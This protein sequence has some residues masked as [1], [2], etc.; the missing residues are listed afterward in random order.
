[1]SNAGTLYMETF[2]ENAIDLRKAI[3]DQFRNITISAFDPFFLLQKIILF[4]GRWLLSLRITLTPG[5][6]LCTKIKDFSEINFLKNFFKIFFAQVNL[7]HRLVAR[8][9][10]FS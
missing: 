4:G 9:G 6:W 3:A 1:M 5:C 10:Q 2:G 7:R 8:L